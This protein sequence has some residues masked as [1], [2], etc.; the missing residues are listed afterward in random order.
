MVIASSKAQYDTGVFDFSFRDER[1]MPFEGAGAI[2]SWQLSLPKTLR[3]FDYGTISDVLLHLSYTSE[4]SEDLKALHEDG[5]QSVVARLATQSM[6]RI[7]SLRQ[8]FPDVFQRLI[9]SRADTEVPWSIDSRHLPFFM[10]R[11]TVVATAATVRFISPLE[12]VAGS[13][14]GIAKKV[15]PPDVPVFKTVKASKPAAGEVHG[16]GL[17]A[18]VIGNVFEDAGI[19]AT[20]IGDYVIKLSPAGKLA[21]A[22]PLPGG[23]V[24]DPMNLHDIVMEVTYHFIPPVG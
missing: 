17:S 24:I 21:L 7:F 19:G 4:F 22:A 13:T 18:F 16:Q 8:E 2:S 10:T 23:G 1:Y 6:A 14:F 20:L 3:V 15:K 11:G 9:G 5:V 12:S